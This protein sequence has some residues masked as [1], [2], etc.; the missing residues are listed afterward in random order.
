MEL[1]H[2]PEAGKALPASPVVQKLWDWALA[3]GVKYLKLRYPVR[4][5]AGY[6]GSQASKRLEPS[7]AVVSVPTLTQVLC[8]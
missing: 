6:L 4:F 1:T 7:E 3:H 5:G 8:K 2:T